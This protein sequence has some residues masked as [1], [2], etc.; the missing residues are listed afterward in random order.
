[1]GKVDRRS[2]ESAGNRVIEG[3]I[4]VP[5]RQLVTGLNSIDDDIEGCGGRGECRVSQHRVI[6]KRNAGGVAVFEDAIERGPI[7]PV[8]FGRIDRLHRVGV[9]KAEGE[10]DAGE[11]EIGQISDRR[12]FKSVIGVVKDGDGEI[13]RIAESAADLESGGRRIVNRGGGGEAVETAEIESSVGLKLIDALG[14]AGGPSGPIV[15]A[16]AD[17]TDKVSVPFRREI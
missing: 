8:V 5:E 16:G 17:R 4:L 14:H 15:P 12:M 1:M 11:V 7:D 6:Q 3:E 10:D 9:E 13:G 2:A